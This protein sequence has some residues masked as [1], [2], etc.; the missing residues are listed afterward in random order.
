MIVFAR[1]DLVTTL[2]CGRLVNLVNQLGRVRGAKVDQGGTLNAPS[3]LGKM[4]LTCTCTCTCTY[5][6][7]I[8]MCHDCFQA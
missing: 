4:M 2:L 5:A 1:R 3:W 8:H 7:M 6:C